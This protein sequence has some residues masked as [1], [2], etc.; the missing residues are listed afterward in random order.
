MRKQRFGP[1]FLV[2]AIMFLLIAGY[3]IGAYEMIKPDEDKICSGVFIDGVDISGMTEAEAENAL[4]QHV[5]QLMQRTLVVDVNGEEV[6][7]TLDE[8]GY[9]YDAGDAIAQANRIGKEDSMFGN[10][11]SIK[12]VEK[13]HVVYP[14][15]ASYSDKLVKKF[16]KNKCGKK[17]TSATN[18]KIKMKDGKLVYKQE[19]DG[20]KIDVDATINT[21]KDA[22]ARQEDENMV[23]IAATVK[24][25]HPTVDKELAERCKDKLGSFT[26]EFNAGNVSRSKNVA[27]AARLINGTVIYPGETFSVHDAISPMTE[28]NGY[29][30]APSYSN[31][32]V[33]DSIGGGVCQVS[34]T[35]YN[36]VL[37]AELE[38]VERSPHSMVVTYVQPSMDAAI[39]GD[40]KDFK[41]RNNTDVPIYLDGGT[42]SGTV[43]FHVYGEETRS[44]ERTVTFESEVTETI[45][46]GADK[47]TYDSSKPESY[48][49]VTQEAH[50][51]YK[52]VL[53]KKVTEN[54]ETEKIQVNSSTYKA[55]PRYVTKGSQSSSASKATPTPAAGQEEAEATDKAKATAKPTEKSSQKKTTESSKKT[56]KATAAPTKVPVQEAQTTDE[57]PA[58]TAVPADD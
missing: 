45:E 38:I 43:Y 9:E 5:Q 25:Q 14:L 35:L 1:A 4:N 58:A 26:T 28:K 19:R 7:T 12:R 3:V 54:G 57:E 34:T 10:Y 40:Y 44:S 56:T 51:G 21:I 48:V 2:L 29:Y 36:A 16:V 52:A 31:G 22:L 20:V 6:S 11:A 8:L 17:C 55:E 49:E 41:F 24:I 27:N 13:E 42:S 46:P 50:T 18:A 15:K 30:A 53:W 37:R 32:Q 39:A 23:R 47:V 33:V